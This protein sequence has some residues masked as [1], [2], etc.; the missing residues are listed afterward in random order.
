MNLNY[1]AQHQAK[2]MW[3]GLAN[4]PID[5]RQHIGFSMSINVLAAIGADTT[6]KFE[7]APPSDADP[8]V[9]GA[10][11]AVK[12]T[13]ICSSNWGAEPLDDATLLIPAGT[14]AGS[15]CTAALP[16]KPDA[17][18]RAIVGA[19]ETAD[20]QIIAVLSGPK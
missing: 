20:V 12:E 4:A 13:L 17:F 10:W 15:M 18:I 8:C 16:C 11:T 2:V 5:L 1:A 19:G 14:P 6:F 7:S 9:P 3:T